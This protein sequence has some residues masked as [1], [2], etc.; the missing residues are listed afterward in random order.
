[1]QSHVTANFSNYEGF[2]Y[3]IIESRPNIETEMKQGLMSG[4]GNAYINFKFEFVKYIQWTLI[5]ATSFVP[6]DVAI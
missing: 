4:N 1:M 6:T 5:T 2:I 3:D